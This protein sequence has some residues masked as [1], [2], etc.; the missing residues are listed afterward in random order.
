MVGAGF[1]GLMAARRLADAGVDVSVLEARERVGGRVWSTTLTNGAVVELGAE[2]IMAGD[3]KVRETAERFGLGLVETGA[4][5]GRREPWGAT[6]APLDAQDRFLERANDAIAELSPARVASMTVGSFLASLDDDEG[7]RSIVMLRLAGTCARD[8]HEVALAE[9]G[10]ERPFAPGPD[11]YVRVGAGNQSIARELAA[12]LPDVRT[13]QAV[14]AIEHEDRGVTVRVGPH[15]ERAEAVVVAIPSPIAARLTFLPA[16]P[17]DLASALA[18]LRLGDASK[19]AVATKQRPPARSRQSSDRSMWCWT[20]NGEDGKPRR[21]VTAF[22]G[23]HAAQ[24]SLGV[25]RGAIVPW[26][27]AVRAMNPDLTLVGEPVLYAWADDPYTLGGYSSWDPASWQR[28]EV[29]ARTVGPIAF[30]GEHTAGEY[31]GTMEGALRSGERAA[32]QVLDLLGSR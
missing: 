12:S 18:S 19:F 32:G 30:A 29:F 21:C 8:L 15:S 9:F 14:D 22:A 23:S 27:E 28:R 17:D 24:E 26:L 16:L 13:G 7:A 3:T 25:T 11:R 5:Y 1:S 4:S 31:H 2:W 20:A 6:A 10:G